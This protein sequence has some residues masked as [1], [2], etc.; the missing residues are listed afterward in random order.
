MS[1]ES[2]NVANNLVGS[3]VNVQNN[4]GGSL[5]NAENNILS[6]L[7]KIYQIINNNLTANYL[8][9]NNSII[10]DWKNRVVREAQIRTRTRT[11]ND[12]KDNE[13]NNI[14]DIPDYIEAIVLPNNVIS[15]FIVFKE[16]NSIKDVI[17]E[18]FN[19][20]KI[21]N[22]ITIN[23]NGIEYHYSTHIIP[24]KE[25]ILFINLNHNFHLLANIF[26]EV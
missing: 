11:M 13:I 24:F 7:E 14:N 20:Y 21:D 22:K 9:I 26:R 1:E 16:W 25:R 4:L 15:S 3:L 10:D 5:V 6:Q 12:L 23:Y 2:V 18:N 19:N 17:L 8:T